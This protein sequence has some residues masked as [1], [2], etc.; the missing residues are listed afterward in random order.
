V[1]ASQSFV[2]PSNA[3]QI[4]QMQWSLGGILAA[5]ASVVAVAAVLRRWLPS[6]PGLR[7]VMLDPPPPEPLD[8]EDLSGLV[9]LEGVATTR[10]V[11]AGKARIDGRV[12]E[13]TTDGRLIEPGRPVRVEAVRGGRIVVAETSRTAGA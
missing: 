6:A 13:V 5:L 7:H 3:Y 11:P 10:L 12:F 2:L 4:R 8:A 1:L 9:G